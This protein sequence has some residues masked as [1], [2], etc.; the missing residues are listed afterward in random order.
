MNNW[1]LI[2]SEGDGSWNMA[3]DEA[4]LDLRGEG[5]IPST[6]RLYVFK[7]S[8]VTIG[9][10]QRIADTVNLDVTVKL[11]IDVIRRPTGGGA[12]FHDSRGEVTYSLVASLDEIPENVEESYRF[13]CRGVVEALK[14]LGLEAEFVPVNDI[15]VNGRKISGSAQLR[16]KNAVLQHGTLMYATRLNVLAAVLKA[17]KEK[18]A[19]HGVSSIADRVT[20]VSRELGRSVVKEEVIQA[21]WKG[22]EKA[23]NK[24]LTPASLTKLELE[25]ARSLLPKYRSRE[26]LFKR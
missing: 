14:G 21:L 26:W 4:L 9:Y 17:R 19:S 3:V 18:L 22:F 16:R 13:I 25:K 10:F 6:V 23:L 24:R 15:V 20:T 8:C 2:I 12:V 5:L 1:R 11:G 7:P